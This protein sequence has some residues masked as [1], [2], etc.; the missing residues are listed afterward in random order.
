MP[1]LTPQEIEAALKRASGWRLEDGKLV[2]DWRFKDFVE[3]MAFVN[4]V[5]SLAETANHHPDIDIRYSNVRL[6][7]TSHDVGGITARDAKMA[8]SINQEL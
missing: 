1:V 7:L 2:R 3:A 5:A 6:G 8:A 4:Q